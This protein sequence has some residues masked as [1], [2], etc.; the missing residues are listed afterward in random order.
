[1]TKIPQTYFLKLIVFYRLLHQA[2]IPRR[3]KVVFLPCSWQSDFV[4]RVADVC[5][6]SRGKMAF[7]APSKMWFY[8]PKRKPSPLGQTLPGASSLPQALYPQFCT[9]SE[10][11]SVSP[12]VAGVLQSAP[13]I[14]HAPLPR[15][16][17]NT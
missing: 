14:K 7:G 3:K 12:H 9:A 2:S 11:G 5:R 17:R 13:T 1:M 10:G 6:D 15:E 8:L 16:A 4:S